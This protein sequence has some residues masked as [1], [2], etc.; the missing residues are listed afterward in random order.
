VE[1]ESSGQRRCAQSEGPHLY[2]EAMKPDWGPGARRRGAA[3]HFTAEEARPLG[4][5]VPRCP[6]QTADFPRRQ[7]ASDHCFF[8]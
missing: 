6:R 2:L 3:L 4:L 1:R 7:D 5:H 8:V